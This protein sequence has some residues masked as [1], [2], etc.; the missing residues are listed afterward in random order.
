MLLAI[1]IIALFGYLG[2]LLFTSIFDIFFPI[3]NDSKYIDRSV[4]YHRHL[5]IINKDKAPI[6]IED[7]HIRTDI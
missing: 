4:H 2:Y 3:K 1:I 7:E 6:T 5:T